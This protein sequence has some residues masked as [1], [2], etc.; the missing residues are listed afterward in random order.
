M[1]KFIRI[2]LII[3]LFCAMGC[4]DWVDVE[5]ENAVTF[6]N[7]FKTEQDAQAVLYNMH[8]QLRTLANTYSYY[9]ELVSDR[10]LSNASSIMM[11]EW[12]YP[13]AVLDAADLILDNL[14]RFPLSDDVLRPYELQAYFAKGIAYF[15]LASNWGDAPIINNRLDYEKVG[16]SSARYVLAEAEK[17][18]LKAMDLP[19]YEDLEIGNVNIR[20]QYASK[21]AAATLL[22][23]IYAWQASVFGETSCWAKA[24][25]YCDTV[26]DGHAG[27]YALAS[28][29]D[30]VCENVLKGE[31]D[32]G[33]W[34]LYVN[35]ANGERAFRYFTWMTREFSDLVA[36]FPVVIT[37]SP[38]ASKTYFTPKDTIL[39]YYDAADKRR[40]AYFY[41][42]NSDSVFV[43]N[44]NGESVADTIREG[45]E[46]LHAYDNTKIA[47]V[48]IR[49]FRHMY[50]T[51][52]NT[53]VGWNFNAVDGNTILFRLADV[54]LLRAECR[55][56]QGNRNGAIADLNTIRR[57]A[58]GDENHGFPNEDDVLKGLDQNLQFAI[59][60]EREKELYLEGHRFL[61][62]RRM[63]NDY[64]RRLHPVWSIMTDSDI[65]DG[66]FY[67]AIMGLSY[68]NNDLL[69]QNVYW[70]RK[71]Q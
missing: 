41:A 26:I 24:E 7:Y 25:A 2:K 36:G 22:A 62:A 10:S 69:E 56:R 65:A 50:Y 19:K 17:W 3:F 70:K 58:Y 64:V 51:R 39:K 23:K 55:A 15:N 45:G 21:G 61:D 46:V 33:I 11:C 32:E 35:Q 68:V 12:S 67:F 16:R 44:V 1:K 5:P 63:G 71:M 34:E 18:A 20:K 60:R 40:D 49:K 52:D 57:R 43:K 66:G 48:F 37:S 9:G 54:I 31:S 29:P 47:N 4:G 27:N 8:Y 14:Y 6:A 59:Y 42:V 30:A 53:S 38:N 28:D 13:Y